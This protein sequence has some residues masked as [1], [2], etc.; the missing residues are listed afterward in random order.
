M[1]VKQ[2]KCALETGNWCQ[3]YNALEKSMEKF[4]GF[5]VKTDISRGYVQTIHDG[6]NKKHP[7]EFTLA[8]LNSWTA[9]SHLDTVWSSMLCI[10]P[11]LRSAYQVI[12]VGYLDK[13]HDHMKLKVSI[14]SQ[15]CWLPGQV[16]IKH[17]KCAL[18]T[19]SKFVQQ[20]F[21]GF[22]MRTLKKSMKKLDDVIL[23][24]MLEMMVL[25][26][27][28]LGNVFKHDGN[29]KKHPIEF[30]LANL[31][32]WTAA[33]HLDTMWSSMWCIYR[34]LRTLKNSMKKLDVMLKE[35]FEMM[36]LQ[37]VVCKPL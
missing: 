27:R 23:K 30:T 21:L 13:R 36:V 17:Q 1:F 18:E 31:N 25:Q 4:F 22:G 34:R 10:Y 12:F 33:S 28:I 6:D 9:P 7:I 2:K 8:N 20:I 5:A 32:S 3:S 24:E 37:E 15:F 35:M 19:L 11:M 29:K 16:T 14:S 26:E